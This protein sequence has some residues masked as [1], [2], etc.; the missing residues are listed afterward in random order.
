MIRFIGE[1]TGSGLS[2]GMGGSDEKQKQ[3]T[4][5]Y[6][7]RLGLGFR[8]EIFFY[9]WSMDRGEGRLVVPL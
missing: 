7:G 3:A 9:L 2:S 4:D 5:R 8:L 6:R 1:Q